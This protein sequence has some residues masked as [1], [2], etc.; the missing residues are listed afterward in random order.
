MKQLDIK[1][2]QDKIEYR[3]WDDIRD[4]IL[5][6]VTDLVKVLFEAKDIDKKMKKIMK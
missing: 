3:E 4:D 5:T 1:N 2:Y 6:H